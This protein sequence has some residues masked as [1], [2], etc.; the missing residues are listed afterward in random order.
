M[1][2][3]SMPAAYLEPPVMRTFRPFKEYGILSCSKSRA[4]QG[5]A[6]VIKNRKGVV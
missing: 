5:L 3:E 6:M 2:K 4:I 1:L